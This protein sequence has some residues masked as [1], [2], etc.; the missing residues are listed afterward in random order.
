MAE[1]LIQ[2]ETLTGL[3]GAL[4]TLNGSTASM[5]AT[6]M[7]PIVDNANTELESQ[8]SVI[9]QIKSALSGKA[10]T[11]G[12]GAIVEEI[13]AELDRRNFVAYETCT[14]TLSEYNDMATNMCTTVYHP[15]IDDFGNFVYR[16]SGVA[17][18]EGEFEMSINAVKG[19]P[20]I[21]YAGGYMY[22]SASVSDNS[23]VAISF[24]GTAIMITL[25]TDDHV[26][27]NLQVFPW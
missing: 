4:R 14:V 8:A 25:G 18:G 10:L 15:V 5:N 20:I 19:L 17:G 6:Q 13:Q 7:K 27:I 23:A 2:E 12:D 22:D 24:Y 21:L 26:D 11:E 9:A 16:A 3:A 1:Y